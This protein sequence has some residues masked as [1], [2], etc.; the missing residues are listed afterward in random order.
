MIRTAL[1][2]LTAASLAGCSATKP[3]NPSVTVADFAKI[4]AST[5][6]ELEEILGSPT[7]TM[8]HKS[9]DC[10]IWQYEATSE[11]PYFGKDKDTICSYHPTMVRTMNFCVASG[12]KIIKKELIGSFYVASRC[13]ASLLHEVRQLS[14][15]ELASPRIP[16]GASESKADVDAYYKNLKK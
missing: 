14:E 1:L 13:P 15:E 3:L 5:A 12:G 7:R 9:L 6:S 16:V 10:K 4:Q 11:R 2:I 8:R